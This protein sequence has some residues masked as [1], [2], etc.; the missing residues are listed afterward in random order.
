MPS[1]RRVLKWAKRT[2]ISCLA[3]ILVMLSF[4]QIGQ[5]VAR[6]RAERLLSDIRG[7]RLQRSTWS[8]AQRIINRWGR[9]G[10]YKG[11]C[12]A[13][14]CE[15]DIS[16]N[17]WTTDAALGLNRFPRFVR[18]A[19]PILSKVV[20]L[21]GARLPQVYSG[22]SV[23]DGKVVGIDFS[24]ATVVP[25]MSFG[26][27]ST[28]SMAHPEFDVEWPER[29]P[30]PE[31][32]VV[33]RYGTVHAFFTE[34]N[35][36]AKDEDLAWLME[37][38]LACMTRLSPCEEDSDLRPAAWT[39]YLADNKNRHLLRQ[40]LDKCDFPLQQLVEAAENIAL[41]RATFTSSSDPEK[42]SLTG[43]LIES[44]KGTSSWQVGGIRDVF[45]I[46]GGRYVD[47]RTPVQ[48][49]LF[50]DDENRVYAHVCGI[51]PATTQNLRIVR[52]TLGETAATPSRPSR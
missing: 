12:D 47:R 37:F 40:R 19:Q 46:D 34:F 26:M 2:F 14:N 20:P 39:H 49:V 52:E 17:D 27:S 24:V 11:T 32:S 22:V 6:S 41:V 23:H 3:V 35:A 8:D 36:A 28:A 4:V 13:S 7:L 16:I 33:M 45:S 18:L 29:N 15:Y 48:I 50:P 43:E 38:N 44:L 5:W 51:I 10:H 31:Y 30:H 42:P 21:F 25:H 1:T 9:W